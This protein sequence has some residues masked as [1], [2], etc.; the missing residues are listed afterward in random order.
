M[1]GKSTKR[2]NAGPSSPPSTPPPAKEKVTSTPEVSNIVPDVDMSPPAKLEISTNPPSDQEPFIDL[3][4]RIPEDQEQQDFFDH[5]DVTPTPPIPQYTPYVKKAGVYT[6]PSRTELPLTTTSVFDL[7]VLARSKFTRTSTDNRIRFNTLDM[8]L[9]KN[10][11]ASMVDRDR[12]I[13]LPT[14]NNPFGIT[15]PY[16]TT[17]NG[18]YVVL[19]ADSIAKFQHDLLRLEVI[20]NTAFDKMLGYAAMIQ[21]YACIIALDSRR[22]KRRSLA[23]SS[24]MKI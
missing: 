16:G 23:P 14:A 18:E 22:Q 12:T 3:Q 6:D 9:R 19:P 17:I 20:M 10:S 15:P 11:L 5:N 8:V 4:K 7:K 21:R 24:F 2:G 13:P 1:T